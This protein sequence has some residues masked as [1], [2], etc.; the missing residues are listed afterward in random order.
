MNVFGFTKAE[1]NKIPG[2][3]GLSN[4]YSGYDYHLDK[5][6]KVVKKRDG[7]LFHF[8]EM[9]HGRYTTPTTANRMQEKATESEKL[10]V[11]LHSLT[12]SKE[13]SLKKLV[14]EVVKAVPELK[15]KGGI[16]DQLPVVVGA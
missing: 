1:A 16:V 8:V 13:A 11:I 2:R 4:P 7:S 6:I 9:K 5:V 14:K 15:Q 12:A 3:G 10:D